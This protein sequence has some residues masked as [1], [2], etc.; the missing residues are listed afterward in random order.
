MRKE[1]IEYINNCKKTEELCVNETIIDNI[2][3]KIVYLVDMVD[4]RKFNFE[5]KNKIDKNIINNL[6]R[7][8][9]GLCNKITDISVNNLDYLLYSG[10]ILL[11][12]ENYYYYFEFA[13]KAKRS[14]TK[15]NLDPSDSTS[16]EDGLIED[17]NVNLTLIKRRIK[18]NDLIVKKY[19]LGLLTKTDCAILYLNK[20]H[21]K[22]ELSKITKIIES[23]DRK[24]VLSINDINI[25][26]QKYELLPKTFITSSPEI[27]ANAIFRGRIVVLLDNSQ[28]ACIVPANLSTFTI[29]K[30]Y[31]NTPKYYTIFNHIFVFFFIFIAIFMMGLFIAIMNFHTNVLSSTFLAN[32]K[33]TERGTSWPMFYEVLLV[34]FLFEFYRFAT[35]RSPNNYIQNIIIILGGLF[36]GQNAIESGTIGATILFLTS[37]SYIAVFAITNNIYLITSINIFRL[38]ILLMS[39]LMGILGFIISSIIVILYLYKQKTS[40][41]YYLYPFIPF[42]KK[43]FIQF[44]KPNTNLTEVE[45]YE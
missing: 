24:N 25:M 21:D 27:I 23:L 6:D 44:F 17:L 36:I 14:I 3:F 34:Y 38:L 32:I 19:Q 45:S 1:I 43:D 33:I 31:I 10:R 11:F 7:H 29:S 22:Y 20:F 26:Y 16:S 40:D 4:I 18:T 9:L 12:F 30:S 39:Y 28:I 8:F 2:S 5:I 41:S 37:I 15:S 35:S 42:N 13:N